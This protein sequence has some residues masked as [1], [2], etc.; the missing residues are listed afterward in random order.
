MKHYSIWALKPYYLGPW[1]LRVSFGHTL[2]RVCF[3]VSRG[4]EFESKF[5]GVWCSTFNLAGRLGG[6]ATKISLCRPLMNK[7]Q[8]LDRDHNR[9]PNIKAFRKGQGSTLVLFGVL[10]VTR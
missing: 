6:G 8:P 2:A 7:P 1:T 4:F 5:Q 3:F 10:G 9:D